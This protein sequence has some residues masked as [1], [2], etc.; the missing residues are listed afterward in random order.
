MLSEEMDRA[1]TLNKRSTLNSTIARKAKNSIK[2][3]QQPGQ[4]A[5]NKYENYVKT[6]EECRAQHSDVLQASHWR[7]A[8]AQTVRERIRALD[9]VCHV[10]KSKKRI[11]KDKTTEKANSRMPHVSIVKR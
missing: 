5:G 11:E 8:L 10:P 9:L 7:A 1:V 4:D 3:I 6:F 2:E